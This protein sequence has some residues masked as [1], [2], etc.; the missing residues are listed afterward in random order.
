[1]FVV[2]RRLEAGYQERILDMVF[3]AESNVKA[4]VIYATHRERMVT[5][6]R[7]HSGPYAISKL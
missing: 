1:M 5:I 2:V 7:R 6:R 3:V 4:A